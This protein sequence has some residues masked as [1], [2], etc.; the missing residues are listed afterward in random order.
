MKTKEF[1]SIDLSLRSF[2]R[3]MNVHS[4]TIINQQ[5]KSKSANSTFRIK[6]SARNKTPVRIYIVNFPVNSFT[7]VTKIVNMAIDVNFLTIPLPMTIYVW[8]SNEYVY[9]LER[10]LSHCLS[11]SM[12]RIPKKIIDKFETTAIIIIIIIIYQ[13]I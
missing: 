2:S 7:P 3:V 4:V 12:Y 6:V 1:L 9:H 8:H 11:L 5:R 10:T 13:I